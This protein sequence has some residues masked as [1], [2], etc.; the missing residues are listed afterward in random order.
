MSDT[1]DAPA[2]ASRAPSNLPIALIAIAGALIGAAVFAAFTPEG[3]AR[4]AASVPWQGAAPTVRD[5]PRAPRPG[6]QARLESDATGTRLIVEARDPAV[7]RELARALARRGDLEAVAVQQARHAEREAWSALAVAESLPPLTPAAECVAILLAR[8]RLAGDAALRM[9]LEAADV[10]ADSVRPGLRV[11]E[12]NQELALAAMAAEPRALRVAMIAAGVAENQDYLERA[13]GVP[14]AALPKLRGE[15]RTF[16]LER[17]DSLRALG[18][19]LMETL[20]PAQQ[21]L[22]AAAAPGELIGLADRLPDPW[23]PLLE[24]RPAA[25]APVV[26]PLLGVWGAFAA[27]GGA[28]G[29]LAALM[30]VSLA[31][32][33]R[34]APQTALAGSEAATL[35]PRHDP[36]A[37]HAWLH[38]VAAAHPKRVAQGVLELAAHALARGERVLIVDAGWRLRLHERFDREARWGLMECLNADMPVLG[39]VQYAGRPGLYLLAYGNPARGENW[40]PLGQHLDDARPHFGRII[41]ALDVNAP[42]P[43]GDALVGRVLEGWWAEPG[44][45]LSKAGRELSERLS[46]PLSLMDLGAVPEATLEGLGERTDALA[47]A[48]GPPVWVPSDPPPALAIDAAPAPPAE[49]IVLDCDLQVR[50]RLRFLAWMRRVQAES[51]RVPAEPIS[52]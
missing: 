13:Q 25:P 10:P 50:Q 35:T 6:E 12:R 40:A 4:F 27:A 8:A 30:L 14:A 22:A 11:L 49:P 41:V 28:A 19:R 44:D 45:R 43:L 46:I 18:A 15:W 5:W 38:A 51:R 9:P 31:R 37:T 29:S 34:R 36:A 39:L 26:R 2:A 20:E 21:E 7:A 23:A 52:R 47:A 42:R 3:V 33:R 1:D 24:A 48:L 16:Q 32:R 17:S